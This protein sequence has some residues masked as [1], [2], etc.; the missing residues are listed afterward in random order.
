[1]NLILLGPPGAGKGTQAKMIVDEFGIPQI[2]TGDILRAAVK[3][4]TP[5]G[6]R[7]KACMEEGK[8][9]SDEIVVG[10]VRD[11]L[12]QPDCGKGF[13]LDGFPRTLAQADALADALA[14]MGRKIESVISFGVDDEALIERLCGRLTCRACGNGYHRSFDPPV[15]AGVCGKCGGELYQRADDQE[16]TIRK[17]LEVFHAETAP[18]VEY[19]AGAGSL[20]ELD[21]M[22]PI[23]EVQGQIRAI[24]ADLA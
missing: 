18:L 8:L 2:S 3:E 14:G 23:G 9:V 6:V 20:V 19:Y 16:S 4:G 7:A 22:A 12:A 17:R 5:M 11:R 1:M 15:E 13:I 10:I 24:L 21:G